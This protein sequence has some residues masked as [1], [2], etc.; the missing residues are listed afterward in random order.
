M[1]VIYYTHTGRVRTS[2]EDGLLVGEILMIEPMSEP[3]IYLESADKLC[4]ADGMGGSRYG[5]VATKT[6]LS[7]LQEASVQSTEDIDIV[8]RQTQKTL[9]GIDTG[10]A[11]AGLILGEEPFVFNIGDC[12]VYKKEGIFLNKLTRDHSVVQQLIDSGEITEEEALVH[13]RKHIL[14]AALTPTSTPEIYAKKIKVPSKAIYLL[15]TDGLWGEFGIDELESFFESDVLEEIDQ[16][17]QAAL[18]NK[19]LKDNISY[20]LVEV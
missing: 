12:R 20:I 7:L 17:I 10:C 19:S 8:V 4:V 16:K 15:C 6:F 14:T 9:R 2:N 5:E 3:E 18:E 13:P 1:K 11:V